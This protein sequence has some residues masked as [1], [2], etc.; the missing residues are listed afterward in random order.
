VP[1]N[2]TGF[3]FDPI[4][5]R[6]PG[7]PAFGPIPGHL[8]LLSD[9][10]ILAGMLLSEWRGHAAS[11]IGTVAIQPNTRPIT[12]PIPVVIEP[13]TPN[14]LHD[15]ETPAWVKMREDWLA[16]EGGGE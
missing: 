11:L 9:T 13:L 4:R 6:P 16:R 14:A 7:R 5:A 3:D 15:P 2:Y 12:G 10:P 8:S 1:V